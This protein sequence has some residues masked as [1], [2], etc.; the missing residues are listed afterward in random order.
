M[1]KVEEGKKSKIPPVI[2]QILRL[3][4]MGAGKGLG[5]KLIEQTFHPLKS[6]ILHEDTQFQFTF[7]IRLALYAA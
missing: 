6:L 1:E 4:D 2:W 3:L 7:V 5:S